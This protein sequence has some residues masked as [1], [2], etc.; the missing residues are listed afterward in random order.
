MNSTP[1]AA[2]AGRTNY[3]FAWT[4]AQPAATDYKMRVWYVN[5]SGNGVVV[6]DSNAVFTIL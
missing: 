1:V 6:D 5:A 3:V 2:V 4:V